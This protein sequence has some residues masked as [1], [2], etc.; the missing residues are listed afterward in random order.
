MSKHVA[1]AKPFKTIHITDPN[2]VDVVAISDRTAILVPKTAGSTNIDFLG[3]ETSELLA[4]VNV[5]VAVPEYAVP[6]RVKVHE[7]VAS[8]RTFS[9]VNGCDLVNERASQVVAPAP[10]PPTRMYP[11][12]NASTRTGPGVTTQEPSISNQ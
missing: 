11:R 7:G 9:C 10:P 6:G 8:E 12:E 1:V 3:E 4:T 5:V 2:I